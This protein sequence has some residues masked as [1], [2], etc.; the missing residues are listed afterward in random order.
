MNPQPPFLNRQLLLI[1]DSHT[2][3]QYG[4]VLDQ[5]CRDAGAIVRSYGSC[6]SH[7]IWWFDGTRTHCGWFARDARGRISRVPFGEL[8]RTPKIASLYA[9]SRP[10]L[11]I[12]SL[13]ANM[14]DYSK[15]TVQGTSAKLAAWIRAHDS[16]LIWV[17]PP[18]IRLQPRW[19]LDRLYGWLRAAVEPYGP[20]ID[21]RPWTWY[22]ETGGD[23][24]HY[25][26]AAGR[27]IA[28]HW[29]RQ[30]FQSITEKVEGRIEKGG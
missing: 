27:P 4:K 21:S 22:P 20:F 19:K 7:P 1:G 13:G 17:G 8:K 25:R 6:S 23:G 10:D 30:V 26:G 29:A 11:T 16:A 9:Q 15:A 28:E 12:V 2:C 3:G 5:A 14:V 18:V 24:I